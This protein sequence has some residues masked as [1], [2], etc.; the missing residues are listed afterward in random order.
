MFYAQ[1][2]STS[3]RFWPCRLKAFVAA[4]LGGIGIIGRAVL[5]GFIVG[6]AETF[7]KYYA[8]DYVDAMV[9]AS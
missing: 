5:G 8:S 6:I 7:V 9:S 3:S 4:V 1:R 2:W